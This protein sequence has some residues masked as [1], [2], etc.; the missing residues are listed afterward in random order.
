MATQLSWLERVFIA[1][2]Q[3][4]FMLTRNLESAQKS[5]DKDLHFAYKRKWFGDFRAES[6]IP[7]NMSDDS[8]KRKLVVALM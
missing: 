1:L 2:S 4:G 5:S 7:A 3:G 6:Y 8:K